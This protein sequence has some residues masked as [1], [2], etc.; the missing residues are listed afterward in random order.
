MTKTNFPGLLESHV[1][2]S[3]LAAPLL[4]ASLPLA[5]AAPARTQQSPSHTPSVVEAARNTRERIANSTRHPKIITNDDLQVQYSLPSAAFPL[6]SATTEAPAPPATGCDSPDAKKLKTEL[7]ATQEQLDQ[8]RHELYSQ[9]Q[10]ISGNDL[11]LTHF[12]PGYSGFFVGAPPLGDSQPP[13]PARITE[14]ELEDK[15]AS[16]TK[17]VRLACEYP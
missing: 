2:T 6:Q 8:L 12:K 17:A 4:L 3:L 9:P 1:V 11:D 14:A 7:Q 15:V 10:V 5:F 16:L 13:V